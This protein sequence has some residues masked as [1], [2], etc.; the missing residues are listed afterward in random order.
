MK[1]FPVNLN[2]SDT[3]EQSASFIVSLFGAGPSVIT[4]LLECLCHCID[5]SNCYTRFVAVL[6][7]GGCIVDRHTRV[8]LGN[9]K[10]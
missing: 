5:L 10:S 2:F 4:P 9:A 1:L 7:S 3:G 8:G 6:L